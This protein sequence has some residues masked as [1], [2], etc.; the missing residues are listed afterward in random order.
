MR[1]SFTLWHLVFSS[2]LALI[3]VSGLPPTGDQTFFAFLFLCVT[4]CFIGAIC[5]FQACRFWLMILMF[6]KE[7]QDEEKRFLES[8]RKQKEK[9]TQDD[10][11]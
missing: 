3:I 4:L 2:G 5:S 1:I 11:S 9:D 6:R 8:F 7:I 10:D